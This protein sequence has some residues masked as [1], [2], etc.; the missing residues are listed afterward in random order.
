MSLELQFTFPLKNG[1]HARPASRF[2]EIANQY[3]SSVTLVNEQT[4]TTA[5]GKSTLSLLGSLTKL[6]DR[7]TLRVEGEDEIRAFEA[8]HIFLEKE[9]PLCDEDLPAPPSGTGGG[10]RIPRILRNSGATFYTGMTVSSGIARGSAFIVS[11]RSMELPDTAH[12]RGSEEE[13]LT[14]LAKAYKEVE[15][16][17]RKQSLHTP[18]GAEGDILKVHLSLLDDTDFRSTIST[19]IIDGHGTAGESVLTAVEHYAEMLHRSE[20]VYLQ[21][22]IL[23]IR[24]V[25]S[26]LIQ[27]MYG[28]SATE[29]EL[30]L[31]K[32]TIVVAANLTPSQFLSL[33]KRLLKGMILS[34]GGTT[35]H[36]S[37]LARSL[38]IP[39]ITGVHDA[40]DRIGDDDDIILDAGR[41][42]VIPTPPQRV[43]AFFDRAAATAARAREKLQAYTALEGRSS[44]GKRLEIGANASS[45]AEVEAAFRN[46]AE[47]IGL[48]R[49]EFLFMDRDA[50]PEEDYQFEIY[51]AA[52]RCAGSRPVIFR[53][54]DIGGDKPVPYLHFPPEENP[55]LGYR[56]VRFYHEHKEIVNPQ[57]RAILRASAFGNARLMFPMISSADEVHRLRVWTGEVMNELQS[58]GLAFNRDIEIGI[59]LEIP[60]TAYIIDQLSAVA[61]FFSVGSNDLTQYFHA[62]DRSNVKVKDLYTSYTPAFLRLLKQIVQEAHT[63]GKWVGLCGEL[64]GDALAIPVF[65]GLGFDEISLASPG[66]AAMKSIVAGVSATKSERLVEQLCSMEGPAQISGALKDFGRTSTGKTALIADD[67]VILASENRSKDD[68]IR[69]LADLLQ[70][71]GRAD[72]A[73][74]VED[75]IW[76]REET[77]STGIGFGVAIP[78]CKASSVITNTVA[79]LKPV[80]PISWGSQDEQPVSMV[81]LI[82][83]NEK[84][85]GE[86]HLKIIARLARRLMHEEFRQSL[87]DAPTPGDVVRLLGESVIA[88]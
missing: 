52:V 82:A 6:G 79:F 85:G 7:C 87:L 61:D 57:L 2:Q 53:T 69:E 75:A 60:S 81:I 11:A 18:R 39:S 13:E 73:D 25:A 33:D 56:A 3:S 66:I 80:S 72:D 10:E 67:V 45:V 76:T 51:S 84:A 37:I 74:L 32:D 49:T 42:L 62:V 59:M 68:V 83:I 70:S 44:D 22:R 20:S 29:R 55:F 35:S 24:D 28:V 5:N 8:F 41:G 78:H 19:G 34:H 9:F 38:G 43:A 26:Q 23:D 48:F 54:L 17:Y 86:D 14:R 88:T 64:G 16:R 77:Y 4:R 58:A 50:P 71:E 36:T 27:A 65:L 47:G 21:E 40:C 12:V 46:G 1:F 30:T 63:R 31:N 15:L